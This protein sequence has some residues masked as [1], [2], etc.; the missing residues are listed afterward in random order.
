MASLVEDR[1]VRSAYQAHATAQMSA[2]AL[3]MALLAPTQTSVQE[4]RARLVMAAPPKLVLQLQVQNVR[5]QTCARVTFA[6]AVL[7]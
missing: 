3:L 4:E 7:V 5:L 2:Q 1:A 6:L